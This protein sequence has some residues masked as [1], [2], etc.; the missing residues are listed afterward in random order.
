MA[1]A[2]SPRTPGGNRSGVTEGDEGR[3]DDGGRRP[4][5]TTREGHGGVP[6]PVPVSHESSNR[7]RASRTGLRADD[8][9]FAA[10]PTFAPIGAVGR[11]AALAF[12][13]TLPFRWS[14]YPNG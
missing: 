8:P 5:P 2:V 3:P 1:A 13:Q 10:N 12:P 4:G 6:V 9:G 11:R 7:S 14:R